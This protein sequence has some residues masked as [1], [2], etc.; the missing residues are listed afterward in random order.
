MLV[1][2]PGGKGGQ[3][4][5]SGALGEDCDQEWEWEWD[6]RG[7]RRGWVLAD[8][9]A[10]TTRSGNTGS[11]GGRIL[12]DGD[13]DALGEAHHL[14]AQRHESQHGVRTVVRSHHILTP[15][16]YYVITM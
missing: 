8:D 3:D 14:A 6:W 7:D 11:N 15:C 12:A 2:A 1:A 9:G 10:K 16:D 13:T 5:C 4:V